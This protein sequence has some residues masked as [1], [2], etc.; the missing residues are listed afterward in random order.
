MLKKRFLYLFILINILIM[1]NV[2]ASTIIGTVIDK[3]GVN[4]RSGAGTN[5]NKTGYLA[6]GKSVTLVSDKKFIN[7]DIKE[8]KECAYWYQVYF[9]NNTNNYMCGELISITKSGEITN[10]TLYYTNTKYGTRINEDYAT[11]RSTPGGTAVDRI[12]LGTEVNIIQKSGN[13]TKISYYNGRTGFVYSKL[14]SNYNDITLNDEEYTKVLKEKG[15]PDSYI[16]FLTYLHKKYPNFI[17]KADLVNKSFTTVVNGEANKNALQ[18]NESAYRASNT[19]RENPNWYT[20]SSPV[21]AFFLD[22]RNYLTEK[23]IFVF[24]KL[25][26]DKD[27]KN[28][29]VILKNMFG[30]SYLANDE[31]INYYLKAGTYGASPIHLAARTI[32]EGGSNSN[33]AAITG[34]ATS[35]GGLKYRS[36]NLDGFYNFYNIGAYQDS[37]TNSAVTRGIAVAAGLVDSYEGTPW[38]TREK[39]IVYGGKFI[40]TAYINN[41]QNT[42]YYQKFNTSDKAHFPSYTHQY[43]TNIIAPASEALSSY[44][45]YID[46]LKL[47]NEE[48]TFIIPVYKDMPK[49]FTTHPIIGDNDNNL[50]S[51]SINNEKLQNFDSDVVEYE[52]YI[53]SNLDK[54]TVTATAK[55]SKAT[56]SGTGEVTLAKEEKEKV[57]EIIVTSE[58]GNKKTYKVKLIRKDNET[59]DDLPIED[60]LK[61]VD[62]KINDL[63]ISGIGENKNVSYLINLIKQANT[64]VNITITNKDNTPNNNILKTGDKLIIKNN[65][66]EKTYTIVIK[67]D[68]N[69][70]GKITAVD[71]LRIQ[72]HILKYTTLKDEYYEACD[73][74]YDN[75]VSPVDMLRIQKHIL[76]YI[77]LK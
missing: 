19:I 47:T 45:T 5:F 29:N 33:Y 1:Q 57:I 9:N 59:S 63:Y 42:L 74:N 54:V 44:N 15:F 68:T 58:T 8:Q 51:I 65:S 67:G 55:S 40:A 52:V 11:V 27:Y 13:W 56:I 43:M 7:S 49:E 76:K 17:F 32:Q 25:N 30:S 31:Y 6:Y 53:N 14:I 18:T 36:N 69:G 77:T 75:S 26:Y 64:D 10:N 3:D 34:T 60:I 21:N 62:V 23:N 28:Y 16:P 50:T 22:P 73:T 66:Y 46:K 20:V 37:Y 70:D 48:F 39:A 12:Y 61:N 72:K 38:N 24:E 4:V 41:N 71:L 2:F 35:T